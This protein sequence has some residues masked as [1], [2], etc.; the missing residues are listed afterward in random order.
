MAPIIFGLAGTA[1]SETE[2]TIFHDIEPAG[3]ILFAHNIA[4]IAQL[5]A[6]TDDLRSLSARDDLPI[7]ID[8]EGGRVARMRPPIWPDFP[9]GARFD[10]LYSIAP[11]TAIEALRCNMAAIALTL[12]EVGISVNCAPLLDIRHPDTHEAIGDRAF[13]ADPLRVASLGRAAL[14]GLAE[15]GVVG[16]IKHMPGQGRAVVDSHHALPVVKAANAVLEIDLEPFIKLSDAPIAMT[17]HVVYQAWDAARCATLS[18]HVIGTIIRNRIGF[19]GLLIS[20]D[21]HMNAL[22]GDVGARAADCLAA[23]CD[24]ALDCWSRGSDVTQVAEQ[25]PAMTEVAATRLAAAMAFAK[26]K[27]DTAP[28]AE[29]IAKRD[30]LLAYA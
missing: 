15:G 6:L 4:D 13:G 9:A 11:M 24:L 28:L 21:L 16:V 18:P 8:Q 30:E 12:A 7:L 23:G 14:R 1:L 25:L 27:S 22:R 19:D 26:P 20:D 3:Y 29:L 10:A 17:A 2:R 5:R